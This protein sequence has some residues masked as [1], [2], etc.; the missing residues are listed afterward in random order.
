MK[1]LSLILAITLIAALSATAFAGEFT[2]NGSYH[3]YAMKTDTG[4]LGT[5]ADKT[6]NFQQRFRLPFSWKVN[7]N[8]TAFMRTDWT[9]QGGSVSSWGGQ[10]ALGSGSSMQIDY[11]WVKISQPNFDLTVGAQEVF[12]GEGSLFDSDQEGLTLDL[13]FNPITVTLAYG[14]LSEDGNKRDDGDFEDAN[15]YGAQIKYSNEAFSI[16]AL[17]AMAMDQEPAFDDKKIG[18]GLFG[19][20]TFGAISIKGELDFFDGDASPTVAYE[21]MNLWGDISYKAS[22]ALTVGVTAYYANGNSSASKTQLTNVSASGWSFAT[23]D[24]LGELAYEKGYETFD[25][26]LDVSAFDPAPDSGIQ[27]I[28]GYAI[29]KATDA[30]TLYGVIGYAT[31]EENVTLDSQTYVIGSVDYAWMPNVILSAGAAWVD[32][33]YS[34]NTID[35]PIIQ[36]VARL[37]V[38]F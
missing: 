13:R 31:P 3:L 28:R 24:Y 14:K 7:D 29:Y 8:V 12:L 32:K 19:N 37:G 35:N 1:R 16:G 33:D 5:D 23:F 15:S 26:A 2:L 34:D 17:V 25:T 21:G 38:S 30:V 11:A 36:Y 6:S 22:E 27:A 4:I 10:N 20:A 9:E 18:Y